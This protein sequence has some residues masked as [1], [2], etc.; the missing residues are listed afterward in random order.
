VSTLEQRSA[1]GALDAAR[2]AVARLDNARGPEDLAA[3]LI[4]TW[5]AVEASLRSLVGSTVLSGQPLIREARQRQLIDFD[6]ANA[7]AAFQ[8]VH[9]RLQN[10]SYHP[11]DSDI[12][13]ARSAFLKLDTLLMGDAGVPP[14][15]P[16][17]REAP[18]AVPPPATPEVIMAEAPVSR[19]GM[20]SWAI[21]AVIV[22]A[23]AALA[24]GA[25]AVFGRR[26]SDSMQ[27][28]IEAYRNGQREVAVS[29]FNKAVREDPHAALPHVYLARMA[30]EVGNFS[31][32]NQELQLALQ[33]EPN[34]EVALREMG[35]NLLTQGNYD[36]ARRF[37]V[38]AVQADPTDKTAQGYLG[39][40]LMR[41]GRSAEAASF[42]TRAGPGPW[43]NC[44]PAVGTQPGMPATGSPNGAAPSPLGGVPRP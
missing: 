22:V 32:A 8:A 41:L 26:G 19:G 14:S 15:R 42:L 6:Q 33:A 13:T 24:G 2:P 16:A 44:T 5:N 36:L 37:Y 27:Q 40:T 23:A 35:A 12:N 39:C 38:R 30:R 7:L 34:N 10:T 17:P 20:P 4:E 29:A 28:G 43:S 3:D 21:L 11:T 9:D 1:R 25:Y 18:P 31:L